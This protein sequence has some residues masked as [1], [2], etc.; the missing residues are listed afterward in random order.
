MKTYQS[1]II[2]TIGQAIGV[3]E[4]SLYNELQ[5]DTTKSTKRNIETYQDAM[6]LLYLVPSNEKCD[7]RHT[8]QNNSA[9]FGD[10][11]ENVLN[12]FINGKCSRGGNDNNDINGRISYN[13]IKTFSSVNRKAN[14]HN[15]S[16]GFYGIFKKVVY[17]VSPNQ[18][19]SCKDI[20]RKSFLDSDKKIISKWTIKLQA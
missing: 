20:S 4:L 7:I 5:K 19:N 11:G 17:W 14:A 12:Y 16:K 10:V 2:V 13:E 6:E 1:N 3:V 8:S 9:N 18:F 15:S